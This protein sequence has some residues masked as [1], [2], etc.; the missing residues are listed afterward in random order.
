MIYKD[1]LIFS[2]SVTDGYAYAMGMDFSSLI[3]LFLT[4]IV[5]NNNEK[6]IFN[7]SNKSSILTTKTSFLMP[8]H[9]TGIQNIVNDIND[10]FVMSLTVYL[11]FENKSDS[12]ET[13]TKLFNVYQ[14]VTTHNESLLPG[15][16]HMWSHP[17]L[18]EQS[19]VLLPFPYCP[20]N[21]VWSA[22]HIPCNWSLL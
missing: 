1:K 6:C 16:S 4:I 14:V 12:E 9:V 19:L 10:S 20:P 13:S 11:S 22:S 17:L 21:F 5:T 18:R 15:K 8:K 2:K 3:M 7:I